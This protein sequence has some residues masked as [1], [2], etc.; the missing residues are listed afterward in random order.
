VPP[1]ATTALPPPTAT[2][3]TAATSVDET[4]SASTPSLTGPEKGRLTSHASGASNAKG[5]AISA[6]TAPVRRGSS[7][8]REDRMPSAVNKTRAA[9]TTLRF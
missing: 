7:A 3:P 2:S 9:S 4:P 6:A 8:S 5:T 1:S